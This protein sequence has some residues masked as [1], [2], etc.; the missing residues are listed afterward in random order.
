MK[1]IRRKAVTAGALA[2]LAL[3]G[4]LAATTPA[5]AAT[6]GAYNGACG[7]G[8]RV[9]AST[10]IKSSQSTVIGTTYVTY[11]TGAA[12][13]CAVTVRNNP[14]K[15]M[16]MEVTLDTWPTG[17]APAKD[18]GSYTSYAGPV[19]KDEPKAGECMNWSGTIDIYYNSDISICS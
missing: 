11:S 14:G 1:Q 17:N 7:T 3:G 4:T 5:S 9:V 8:F 15:R 6:A 16:F 19:Y 2:V 12:Q 18:Y 10:P 13:L